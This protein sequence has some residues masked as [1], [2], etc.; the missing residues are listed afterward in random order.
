MIKMCASSDLIIY[1]NTTIHSD[2]LVEYNNNTYIIEYNGPQHY[3]AFK[4]MGGELGYQ[5]RKSR[6]ENLRQYC[7]DNNINLLEIKY[8]DKNVQELIQQFLNVPSVQ[9]TKQIITEQKR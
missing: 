1:N 7:K 2:F 3:K 6:D 4:L 8:N 9:E 5:I